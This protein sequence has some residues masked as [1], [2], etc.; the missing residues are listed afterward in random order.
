[1]THAIVMCPSVGLPVDIVVKRQPIARFKSGKPFKAII[2][3]NALTQRVAMPPQI[4]PCEHELHK[5]QGQGGELTG[6]PKGT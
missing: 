6:N 4:R 3:E 5:L 2:Y 1:M